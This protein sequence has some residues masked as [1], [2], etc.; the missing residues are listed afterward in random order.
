MDKHDNSEEK[1]W[2]HQM[3]QLY[4][5]HW[6]LGTCIHVLLAFDPYLQNEH[7]K[8]ICTFLLGLML[9]CN[10]V[11]LFEYIR[12]VF[13]DGQNSNTFLSVLYYLLMLFGTLVW[14]IV[15]SIIINIREAYQKENKE[16][17]KRLD[18]IYGMQGVRFDSINNTSAT[19]NCAICFEDY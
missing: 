6:V 9:G 15:I 8:S 12:G 11:I 1:D 3:F 14:L 17:K 16:K 4:M 7:C 18:F 13:V 5:V 19:T 10:A 2:V